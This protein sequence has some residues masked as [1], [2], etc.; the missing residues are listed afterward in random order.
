MLLRSSVSLGG[1]PNVLYS[2]QHSGLWWSLQM[3]LLFHLLCT[4]DVNLV[5]SWAGKQFNPWNIFPFLHRSKQQ[6]ELVVQYRSARSICVKS[7]NPFL[8]FRV[9][10]F[11]GRK[12]VVGPLT[13]GC[14]AWHPKRSHFQLCM[15]NFKVNV[16]LTYTSFHFTR[17]FKLSRLHKNR[18][19]H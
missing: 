8:V 6:A 2:F 7:Q 17:V 3:F 15:I 13:F 18:H 11:Y 1:I 4:Y 16:T 10:S 14:Y 9:E 5:N 19:P 12:R